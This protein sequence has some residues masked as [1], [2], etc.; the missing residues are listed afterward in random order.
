M[1]LRSEIEQAYLLQQKGLAKVRKTI[2][3]EQ[4]KNI[5]VDNDFVQVISGI[6]RSGKSTLLYQ[7]ME[8]YQE[9]A[10]FNFEDSRVVNFEVGDFSKLDE[11][12]PDSTEAYFFDEIQN[13]SK[14]E[15]YIRRLRDSEKKVFVTG[16][17]ASLLS[18][19][20]G[21]RLTGRY[22]NTEL[23]PF[24]YSEYLVFSSQKPEATSFEQYLQKGGFP[25]FL[26]VQQTEILQNLLKDI[27]LRDIAIRYGIRNTNVLLDIALF[28]LSNVGKETTYNSLKRVFQVGSVSTVVDYLGWMEDAYLLFFLEKF[29]WSAKS[30]S[31]SP[32]KV[33]AIDTGFINTNSLS[34]TSDF[35]RLLENAVYIYFH[36]NGIKMYYFREKKECDFLLFKDRTCEMPVQVCHDL[37]SDNKQR[38]I[39]GLMEALNFF[40]LEEGYIVTLRQKDS[41]TLDGR[42]ITIVPAH[43]FFMDK[44]FL[45]RFHS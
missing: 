15:I 9:V 24:S 42:K 2:E 45:G 11:I 4:L 40:D 21:T 8:T 35:G 20:L 22:L 5:S 7:L 41:L 10:Y 6:R 29:S 30:R 44:N 12:I 27:L 39:D 25:E 28:L 43:E 18:K 13:V 34:F 31:V 32:R 33:Y 14:W 16:S 38:E 3:R 37:N 36:S 26:K 19:D 17:N 1:L 23:F